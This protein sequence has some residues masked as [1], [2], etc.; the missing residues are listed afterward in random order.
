MR[1]PPLPVMFATRWRVP[2]ARTRPETVWGTRTTRSGQSQGC[3]RRL[4][5]EYTQPIASKLPTPEGWGGTGVAQ[6]FPEGAPLIV[7]QVRWHQGKEGLRSQHDQFAL[8]A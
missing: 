7:V 2:I 3:S 1:E 8:G 6:V 4:D 5:G